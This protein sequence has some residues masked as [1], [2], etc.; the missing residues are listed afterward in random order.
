MGVTDLP[1][2]GSAKAN[3]CANL[4]RHCRDGAAPVATIH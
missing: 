2:R 1:M 3:T 4:S